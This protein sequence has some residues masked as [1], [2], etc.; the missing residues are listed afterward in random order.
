MN[1]HFS[2]VLKQLDF[3]SLTNIANSYIACLMSV[4][5]YDK[6]SNTFL[7]GVGDNL[8]QYS[9]NQTKFLAKCGEYEDIPAAEQ[10]MKENKRAPR[11][12][13]NAYITGVASCEACVAVVSNNKVV[14]T[15]NR[16]FQKQASVVVSGYGGIVQ[17]FVVVSGYEGIVWVFAC[18]FSYKCS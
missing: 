14:E 1:D 11:A 17:V 3:A 10:E 7:I 6:H 4:L 9:N 13:G 16:Q 18:Y 15:F 2:L 8:Y 5:H 12:E